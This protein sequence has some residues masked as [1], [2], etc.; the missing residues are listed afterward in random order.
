MWFH[1]EQKGKVHRIAAQAHRKILAACR[2]LKFQPSNASASVRQ[3]VPRRGLVALCLGRNRPCVSLRICY[4]HR[5]TRLRYREN[6]MLS[7]S[8]FFG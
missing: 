2:L 3:G 1:P 8:S 7:W 6:M 5:V 4:R